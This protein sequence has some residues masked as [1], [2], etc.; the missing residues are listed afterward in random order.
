M[1]ANTGLYLTEEQRSQ[2]GWIAGL[3]VQVI[4]EQALRC[5]LALASFTLITDTAVAQNSFQ[6]IVQSYSQGSRVQTIEGKSTS[7]RSIIFYLRPDTK[8]VNLARGPDKKSG[9]VPGKGIPIKVVYIPDG[10]HFGSA[11][12]VRLDAAPDS[13]YGALAQF[14]KMDFTE[15]E[16]EARFQSLETLGARYPFFSRAFLKR[17][18]I[19]L[20]TEATEPFAPRVINVVESHSGA[21]PRQSI[22]SPAKAKGDLERKG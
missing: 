12:E 16:P 7:G 18:Q 19:N 3:T 15:F 5:L 21:C 10:E 8:F 17:F 20:V 11:L 2:R 13:V 6:G 9:I 1:R 22:D 4:S 14:V